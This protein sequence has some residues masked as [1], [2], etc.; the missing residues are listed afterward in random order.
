MKIAKIIAAAAL[1]IGTASTSQALI[2]DES[3][4]GSFTE[5]GNL[6]YV[7]WMVLDPIEWGG[8]GYLYLYQLEA[9]ATAGTLPEHFTIKFDTTFLT[10]W[11]VYYSDDLD[12]ANGLHPAHTVG[13]ESEPYT[14]IGDT[15][16]I[17]TVNPDNIS[18]N[19]VGGLP[20][21][22]ETPVLYFV[23]PRA[24]TFGNAFAID[25]NA[26]GSQG[27]Y[28]EKVPVPAPDAAATILMLGAAVTAL[29]LLAR[30][31]A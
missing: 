31:M 22:Y 29:G 19:I 9:P 16:I 23:D 17:T 26:W 15:A 13:G 20:L 11:G 30:K 7:D 3:N 4:L 28:G 8:Q 6:L 10:S 21:G 25:G 1:I 2:M 24:P 27:P 12:V 18:W 14:M 5:P